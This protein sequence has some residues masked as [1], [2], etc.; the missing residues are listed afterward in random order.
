MGER[1]PRR[2]SIRTLTGKNSDFLPRHQG[3]LASE[4]QRTGTS[5][6]ALVS[7]KLH[8]PLQNHPQDRVQSCGLS[9]RREALEPWQIRSPSATPTKAV[10][11]A[12]QGRQERTVRPFSVIAIS[13][14][15]VLNT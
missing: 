10:I 7:T 11:A 5:A 14:I 4:H 8:S 13:Y 1:R 12:E 9:H 3:I 6:A 15:I 2:P